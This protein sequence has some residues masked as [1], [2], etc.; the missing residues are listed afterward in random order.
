MDGLRE[1]TTMTKEPRFKD[2]HGSTKRRILNAG[3]KR[4]PR[5]PDTIPVS[6]QP[7]DSH[8]GICHK[9]DREGLVS[10]EGVCTGYGLKLIPTVKTNMSFGDLYFL[11]ATRCREI[12]EQKAAR[13]WKHVDAEA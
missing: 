4:Q 13:E 7:I 6:M 1:S 11:R 5:D 2:S 3:M 10:T 12:A 8:L 9:C